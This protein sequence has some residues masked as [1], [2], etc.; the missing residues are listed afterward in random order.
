MNSKV[1]GKLIA[2]VGA[3]GHTGR[4]VVK[5]LRRRGMIPILIGRDAHKLILVRDGDGEMVRTAQMDDAASLNAALR[6]A[7]AV[8]N[9]AGPFFDTALPVIDAA[10]R[11]GIHYLDVSAEQVTVQTIMEARHDAAVRAGVTLLPAAAF[12]GGLADL[13]ATSAA[14]GATHLDE[15]TVAVGLDS[16]HPTE[17]TRITGAR[18]TAKRLIQKDGILVPVNAAQPH[19]HWVFP[20]PLGEQEM[21]MVPF[22]EMITLTGHLNVSSIESWINVA[23]LL[24]LRDAKTPPPH[25]SSES[26]RSEQLF[27]MDV[28]VCAGAQ[29]TRA[30]ATG[31]DIY[32]TSAPI[33]VEAAQRLLTGETHATAGVRALGEIFE[34]RAFLEAL[35]PDVHTRYEDASL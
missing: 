32:A 31:H 6:G 30:T 26:G 12:Y 17:G 4:F 20:A 3:A 18:N 2:V 29:I 33:I 25:V 16:W 21:V 13:L 28:R 8:I 23:A 35:G 11:A 15:I 10:L 9:C 7:S 1:Q 5:E 22:S 34:A 24:D 19:R 27:V 14:N